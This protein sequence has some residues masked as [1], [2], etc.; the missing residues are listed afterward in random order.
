MPKVEVTHTIV[1]ALWFPPDL[2]SNEIAVPLHVS[3]IHALAISGCR[4]IA[5]RH[6]FLTVERE[7]QLVRTNW[8]VG[9]EWKTCHVWCVFLV[10][11]RLPFIA[12]LILLPQ[13]IM[14]SEM[15]HLFL[16][17]TY[18]HLLIALRKC[19]CLMHRSVNQSVYFRAKTFVDDL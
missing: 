14:R 7:S 16:R 12:N 6:P 17:I 2:L 1:R 19:P 9:I 5:W 11:D 15:E 18:F 10:P 4:T 3:R 8:L 13:L